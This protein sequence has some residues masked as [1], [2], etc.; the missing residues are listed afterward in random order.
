[1]QV[2][3]LGAPGSGKGALLNFYR[4]RGIPTTIDAEQSA[5]AV[6]NAILGALTS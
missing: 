6:S 5:R 3:L 4:Q 1:M 2:V